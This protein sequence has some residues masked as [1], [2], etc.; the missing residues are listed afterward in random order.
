[1]SN[2]SGLLE[3]DSLKDLRK[4]ENWGKFITLGH[5]T[6]F[7]DFGDDNFPHL[8]ITTI[9]F[10]DALGRKCVAE[11]TFIP[12]VKEDKKRFLKLNPAVITSEEVFVD[13]KYADLWDRLESQIDEGVEFEVYTNSISGADFIRIIWS[14]EPHREPFEFSDETY[15]A[16]IVPSHMF[17]EGSFTI[18]T[19]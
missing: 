12:V 6:E 4:V 11:V 1:M 2:L 19:V 10:G 16:I 9:L 13:S 17:P 3:C 7:D 5:P 8:R 18:Y 14:G 15:S